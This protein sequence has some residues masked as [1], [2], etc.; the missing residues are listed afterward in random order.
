MRNDFYFAEPMK[1]KVV[2]SSRLLLLVLLNQLCSIDGMMAICLFD[3]SL[4]VNMYVRTRGTDGVL[5]M[6]KK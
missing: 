1:G 6:K 4:V 3:Q 2:Y 5:E